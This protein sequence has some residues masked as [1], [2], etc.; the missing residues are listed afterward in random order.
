MYR[1]RP[2][3]MCTITSASSSS[4]N[5]RC[6]TAAAASES[7]AFLF[8]MCS[9]FARGGQEFRSAHMTIK[10]LST[11]QHQ[12]LKGRSRFS[13]SEL[14]CRRSVSCLIVDCSSLLPLMVWFVLPTTDLKHTLASFLSFLN[15]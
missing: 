15:K 9:M 10:E 2:I 3:H 13:C 12:R 11:A 1:S 7:A 5:R 4:G 6:S 14:S 8:F